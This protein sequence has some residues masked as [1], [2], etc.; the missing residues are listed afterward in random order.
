MLTLNLITGD[1]DDFGAS[2]TQIQSA[3]RPLNS[4]DQIDLLNKLKQHIKPME[5]AGTTFNRTLKRIK[6]DEVNISGYTGN[7]LKSIFIRLIKPVKKIRTLTEVISDLE[8]N[9]AKYKRATHPDFPK[10]PF[11][12]FMYYQTE[13]RDKLTKSWQKKQ[14]DNTKIPTLVSQS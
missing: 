10:K 4:D 8:E 9:D 14:S 6:W 5:Y 11:S 2:S 12:A 3:D 13:N 7:Q 1:D